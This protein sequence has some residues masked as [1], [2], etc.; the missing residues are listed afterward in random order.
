[1]ER[2]QGVC[3]IFTLKMV[4]IEEDIPE[5]TGRL[6]LYNAEFPSDF[7]AF[8]LLQLQKTHLN[9]ETSLAWIL[10]IDETGLTF[11]GEPECY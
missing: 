8:I 1:M 5:T 3:C 2:K 10:Y 6:M 4:H 9:Y 11:S 7:I